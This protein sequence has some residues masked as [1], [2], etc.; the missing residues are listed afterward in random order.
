MGTLLKGTYHRLIFKL[1][2]RRS[3]L[4]RLRAIIRRRDQRIVELVA[5]L[6]EAKARLEP[7]KIPGH[8]FP[9]EL[10]ALAVFMVT[11]CNASLRCAAKTVGFV[12]ELWG[13]KCG[14][15]S[16]G[17]VDNWKRRLGLYVLD[18]ADKKVG[19]Y[20]GIFDESIQIGCEKFMLLVGVKLSEDASH[21]RP[22]TFE[23]VEILGVEVRKSWKG[24][25]VAEFTQRRLAHH[26]DLE[27]QYMISDQGANLI[28][29]LN[30]L[31]I[32]A[33]SDCS[34]VIMNV[35]KKLLANHDVLRQLTTFM[36]E[37]R[38]LNILSKRSHLCPA[39][40]RDKDRFLRLFVILDWAKRID[41][42]WD[43]LPSDYQESLAILRSQPV[44]KLLGELTQ[45]RHLVS[46]AMGIL[47]TS[48]LNA[49]SQQSWK[50]ALAA[51]G[52]ENPLCNMATQLADQVTAYFIAHQPLITDHHRL[53]CCSDIVE[54]IF[55]RYKNKGGM[56]AITADV[57][58]VALY[59][60]KIDVDLVYRGLTTVNQAMITQWHYDNTCD[61][62]YS[63]IRHLNQRA[64]A[65]TAA[66]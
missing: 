57:L 39:T 41:R 20:A 33:V 51:Y 49:Q 25:E 59:G 53:L 38:K 7:T 56:Q 22:L 58:G 14:T 45:L 61:N 3:E 5:E 37:Y 30:I 24:D 10:I 19:R 31:G 44:Q 16:H 12:A 6:S 52:L 47:K 62:R 63:N 48:G 66:A 8:R 54:A 15:P 42:W 32:S 28:N 29:A 21:L 64:K 43:D 1:T 4:Q 65:S 17:T 50:K 35:L 40:L 34:H 2:L 27:L 18:Y 60:K 36:G 9:A 11:H 46:L 23:D 26:E 55:G 13:W